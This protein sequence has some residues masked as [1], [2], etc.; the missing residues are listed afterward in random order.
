MTPSPRIWI[1]TAATLIFLIG[2][3]AG[4][5]VD[6]TL[7]LP[8]DQGRFGFAR[9]GGPGMGPG[10]G[11]PGMGPGGGPGLG[12]GRGPGP[13]AGRGNMLVQSPERVVADL[14]NELNLKP[15]QEAAI[16]KI[17]EDWRPRVQALQEN[18]RKEFV[19]TQ[20]ALHTEIARTLTPE[21]AKRFETMSQRM[22]EGGRGRGGRR[23]GE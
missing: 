3:L 14:D 4:V 22:I 8:A 5:V 9:G 18:A 19:S 15:D 12:P 13:G 17:V 16:L 11:G 21:Q 2:A 10:G 7:L 20:Q 1:A 23:G 6:R